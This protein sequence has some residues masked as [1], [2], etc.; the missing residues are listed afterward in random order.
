M[1]KTSW[2]GHKDLW[3]HIFD[4]LDI[5]DFFNLELTDKKIRD[6]L[7]S[8]YK[9]CSQKVLK[10]TFKCNYKRTFFSRYYNSILITNIN[11][12]FDVPK[13]GEKEES[14]ESL[15]C[16]NFG[17]SQDDLVLQLISTDNR[18]FILYANNDLKTFNVDVYG[19]L[20]FEMKINLSYIQVKKIAYLES[21]SHLIVIDHSGKL[22]SLYYPDSPEKLEGDLNDIYLSLSNIQI[23]LNISDLY[24]I[25]NHLLLLDDKQNFF[26]V[27]CNNLG[28]LTVQDVMKK[29][30]FILIFS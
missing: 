5:N 10:D 7:L 26:Y 21:R 17:I 13:E 30:T 9:R 1:E 28:I 4:C 20:T 27:H 15:D 24:P 16:K 8:Y 6:K 18:I 19:N 25:K 2:I 22:Y 29:G 23:E 14:K 12:E 11:K 3:N